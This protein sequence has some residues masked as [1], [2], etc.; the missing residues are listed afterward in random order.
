MKTISRNLAL[1]LAVLMALSVFAMAGCSTEGEG[2]ETETG[3]AEVTKKTEPTTTAKTGFYGTDWINAAAFGMVGDGKTAN[4]EKFD[5]Y[6]KY[7][8]K[9]PLYFPEGVYCFEK[10]LNFPDSMYV[11]MDPRAELKCI[12]KEP[13]DYFITL[14]G[15]YAEE[16]G[17]WVSF[18]N[19]AHQSGI[20]G[21]TVNCDYKAK[22][23]LGLFQGLHST[24]E[25]VMI[26]NVLEKGI[27]T[28][29][30]KT[31]DGCYTFD[32]VYIYNSRS[33]PGTYGVY[34]NNADNHFSGCTVVNFNTGFFSSGGVFVECSAWN[35]DMANVETLTF[36]EIPEDS[37]KS[38]WINPAV[39][40]VRYGFKLGKGAAVSI[41]DMVWITNSVM[42]EK[43]L[44]DEYPR[45][46]FYAEDPETARVTV[47]GLS[48]P[49]E[50]GPIAFSNAELPKS[51]F[52]NVRTPERMDGPSAMKHFRNDSE[53]IFALRNEENRDKGTFTATAKTDFNTLTEPGVY[54]CNLASGK[55]GANLPPAKEKGM[56]TVWETN[57]K[58]LQTFYGE[59]VTAH[60]T[61][62]GAKWGNWIVIS[63]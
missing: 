28:L 36:A 26:K 60:R 38:V 17:H 54:E 43:D 40:T 52:L 20:E 22:C 1:L 59:S 2:A 12:A 29:I 18:F 33:L 21:G 7:Y 14:R 44:Q 49:W 63:Q 53:Y 41:T 55:G 61:F 39:D 15:Q 57:G 13:L 32:N 37:I 27:Q 31:P 5:E 62:N 45:T 30:S 24:F 46:M 42:Y 50:L 25:G 3:T 47:T 6:I 34:D 16:D 48:I 23:A 58:I 9:T 56:M 8:S 19:Y 4:D 10:T 51:M 35:I 11:R